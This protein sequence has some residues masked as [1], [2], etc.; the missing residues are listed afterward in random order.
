MYD[1]D[2]SARVFIH[3]DRDLM[4]GVFS[5]IVKNALNAVKDINRPAEV[6]IQVLEISDER[7]VRIVIEDNGVGMSEEMIREI[8]G[9]QFSRNGRSGWGIRISKFILRSHNGRLEHKSRINQGTKAI[10]TLPLAPME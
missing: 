6:K 4:Q 8:H 3:A 1:E 7:V 2:I 10:I 9:G 5:N